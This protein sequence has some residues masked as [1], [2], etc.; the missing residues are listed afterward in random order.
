VSTHI[1]SPDRAIQEDSKYYEKTNALGQ[2][3]GGGG[4]KRRKYWHVEKER[5]QS[6]DVHS[7]AVL[8]PL[9]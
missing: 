7:Y 5:S 6:I 2:Q 4:I 1:S 3:S 8:I 9:H